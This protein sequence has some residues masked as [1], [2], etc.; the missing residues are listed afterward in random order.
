VERKFNNATSSSVTPLAYHLFIRIINNVVAVGT[1][2]YAD[3]FLFFF[4][5][6]LFLFLFFFFFFLLYFFLRRV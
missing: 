3:L 6:F 1:P 5:L 2:M 4:F